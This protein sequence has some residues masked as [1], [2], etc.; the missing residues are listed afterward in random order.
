MQGLK[1]AVS[2]SLAEQA[3]FAKISLS[4]FAMIWH[5]GGSREER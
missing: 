2:A 5:E 1:A 4:P 3:R